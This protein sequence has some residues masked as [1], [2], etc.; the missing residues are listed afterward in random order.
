MIGALEFGH[1]PEILGLD[2]HCIWWGR[3]F[4]LPACQMPEYRRRLPHFHP[5]GAYLF[6]TWRLWRSLPAKPDMSEHLTPGHAFVVHDRLLHQSVH[7]FRW[8]QEPRIAELVAET[9]IIGDCQRH[10]YQLLAWVVMPNHVHLLPSSRACLQNHA[11]G[12]GLLVQSSQSHS[13]Q[14]RATVLAR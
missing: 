6:L 10:F 2:G 13:G 11:M 4:R 12:E 14:N 3:R 8:L 1:F 5:D 7:G 9:L